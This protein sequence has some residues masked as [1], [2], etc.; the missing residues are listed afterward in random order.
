MTAQ[1]YAKAL[2]E[3]KI[4]VECVVESADIIR[5]NQ[6]LYK[7]LVSPAVSAASKKAVIKEIFPIEARNF[8]CLLCDKAHVSLIYDI[9]SEYIKYTDEKNGII[10]AVLTCIT[11][12]DKEQTEGIKAFLRSKFGAEDVKLKIKHDESLMGGFVINACG[13]EFDR[14]V[15]GRL[16]SLRSALLN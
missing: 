14:S 10:E 3:L 16:D 13:I 2:Y 15:K 11:E 5:E 9:E 4:P 8:L 7:V 12:P 6:Q 1:N